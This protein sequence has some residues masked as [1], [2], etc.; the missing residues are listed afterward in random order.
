MKTREELKILYNRI[1][2]VCI[3]KYDFDPTY[4]TIDVSSTEDYEFYCYKSYFRNG[5]ED[6]EEAFIKLS[7]LTEDLDELVRVR[8]EKEN[9]ACLKEEEQQ[10]LRDIKRAE[11]D[12]ERRRKQFLELKKEF[13]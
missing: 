11:E 1:I 6:R 13:E 7:D 10:K 12:K 9:I 2:Q 4:V 8:I 5:D 3:A